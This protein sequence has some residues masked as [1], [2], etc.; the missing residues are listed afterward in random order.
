MRAKSGELGRFDIKWISPANRTI[1]MGTDNVV[2]LSFL[3]F[4]GFNDA[5][6]TGR[7]E[8]TKEFLPYLKVSCDFPVR[9][10][11]RSWP[12]SMTFEI[13]CSL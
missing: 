5:E 12:Q 4:R 1:Q 8:T 2:G 6:F 7:I 10:V 9:L 3:A 13:A 11:V